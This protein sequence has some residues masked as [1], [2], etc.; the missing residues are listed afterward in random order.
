MAFTN[1][2]LLFFNHIY[3]C[4]AGSGRRN[5]YTYAEHRNQTKALKEPMMN[6][7]YNLTN[8]KKNKLRKICI[9]I[10]IAYVLKWNLKYS[11]MEYNIH[12]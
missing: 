10:Y 8:I 9:K 5:W 4:G 12:I 11:F 6:E 1:V 3:I 2:Y 7:R